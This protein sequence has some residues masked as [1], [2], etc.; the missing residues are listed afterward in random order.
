VRLIGGDTSALY[1]AIGGRPDVAVYGEPVTEAGR[2][3]IL[4]FVR[5]QAVSITAHR[6]GTPNH[7][8]DDLI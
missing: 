8:T 5:E 3:E 7:L 1:T 4:P 2:L 6:F